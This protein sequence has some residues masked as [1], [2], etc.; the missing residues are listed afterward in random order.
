[1]SQQGDGNDGWTLSCRSH[2][3]GN[4]RHEREGEDV[5]R[6]VKFTWHDVIVHTEASLTDNY[7]DTQGEREHALRIYLLTE[8]AFG[9]NVCTEAEH[10]FAAE[11][12]RWD[13]EI[14]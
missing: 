8:H 11:A 13:E 2:G 9:D 12:M 4:R 10:M 14:P 1:M 3:G 6:P 5:G 7:C